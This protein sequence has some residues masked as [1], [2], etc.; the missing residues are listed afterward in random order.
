MP[1]VE[2]VLTNLENP[3]G[4]VVY[5]SGDLLVAEAGTGLRSVDPTLWSGK[6]TRFSDLNRDGDFDDEAEAQPWFSHLP[7]YQA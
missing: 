6:L 7:T 1:T 2:V 5:Q 3:R 4:I